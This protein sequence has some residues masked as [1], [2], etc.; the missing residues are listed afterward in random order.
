[1]RNLVLNNI[2]SVEKSNKRII[3][4]THYGIFHSDDVLGTAL[5]THYLGKDANVDVVRINHQADVRKIKE[6][7]EKGEAEVYVIDV[8]RI[9]NPAER[10]FDHHQFDPNEN[11]NAAAGL[12]YNYLKDNNYINEFEQEELD[13]FVEMVDKNDIGKWKGPYEGTFPWVVALH[14]GK[15]IYDSE[16]DRRFVEAVKMT[17]KILEDISNRAAMKIE[18]LEVLKKSKEI[19]PGVLELPKYLP[20]WND[21][22]FKLPEF[23]DIDLVIWYDETQN[24]WKIQQ[25]PDAPGSFGRRGRPVPFRDP[26]PEGCEFLHRGNFFGVFNSKE[27]LIDYIKSIES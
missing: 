17:L 21:L 14:N 7:L 26:L 24:K 1:M 16:Q 19:L 13:L 15:D 3:V 9:Y 20:G 22:I 11:P 5:I 23:D 6:F 10:F 8:G 27:A 25:V 4:V 12:V 18:S 2:K